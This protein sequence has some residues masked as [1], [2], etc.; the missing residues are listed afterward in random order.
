MADASERLLTRP[1]GSGRILWQLISGSLVTVGLLLG[2]FGRRPISLRQRARSTVL[3]SWEDEVVQR[4]ITIRQNHNQEF[5]DNF[6]FNNE[7]FGTKYDYVWR[8]SAQ[9]DGG[10]RLEEHVVRD[11][12]ARG[13]MMREFYAFWRLVLN[14]E[15]VASRNIEV[16]SYV[17][18]SPDELLDMLE[19]R[20]VARGAIVFVDVVYWALERDIV[21]NISTSPSIVFAHSAMP[22]ANASKEAFGIDAL[23]VYQHTPGVLLRSTVVRSL[24]AYPE[25]L[26]I[27]FSGDI[28]CRLARDIR[29]VGDTHHRIFFA[30]DGSPRGRSWLPQGLEL[31]RFATSSDLMSALEASRTE[32][33][34]SAADRRYIFAVDM[35]TNGRKPSRE[36]LV[37]LLASGGLADQLRELAVASGRACLVQVTMAPE[38]LATVGPGARDV[39]V[40]VMPD[41]YEN[42]QVVASF[43]LHA[44]QHGHDLGPT[45]ADEALPAAV[46]ALAPAG[47]V[48][49]SGRVLESLLRGE[50]PVVDVTY[51]T[52][53]G[54][55]AKGCE[56]PA[57]FWQRGDPDSFP[58]AAPFVFVDDWADLPSLLANF[59]AT[60]DTALAE[61]FAALSL[62]RT[63]LLAHLY[64]RIVD[65]AIVT[66]ASP[67]NPTACT[68]IPLSR[69]QELQNIRLAE[70]YYGDSTKWAESFVDSPELPGA[71]CTLHFE[72]KSG[73]STNAL[74]FSPA[75]V[76]S[77]VSD[78]RCHPLV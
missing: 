51:R 17:H 19:S 12:R 31:A 25:P 13:D 41:D 27:V 47:D 16:H 66:S 68:T 29:L 52:D 35:S 73:Q 6:F 55:S 23:C 36:R 69:A 74:C 48:W 60:N 65:A 49:S 14:N 75:C 43:L 46:F 59:G 44:D 78:F 56:D 18:G 15:A 32:A 10:A 7:H 67:S 64:S 62:Y 39:N 34:S 3:A 37:Q 61:R 58:Y 50:I 9:T 5:F 22:A 42:G 4:P 77:K 26:V 70:Q 54:A 1:R 63:R 2:V 45:T 71:G 24:L 57:G 72:G 28:G 11:I 20:S 30:G 21:A 40:L 76:P 38:T 8:S 53:G 33:T